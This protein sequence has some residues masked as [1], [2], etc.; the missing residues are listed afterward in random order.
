MEHRVVNEDRDRDVVFILGWGTRLDNANVRRMFRTLGDAGYRV[1]AFQIPTD[2]EDFARDYV[3]PIKEAIGGLERFVLMSHSTGGLIAPYLRTGMPCIFIS[4]WWGIYGFKLRSG[5]IA[6]AK[7][8]RLR[9]RIIPIDFGKEELGDMVTEEDWAG[10]PK[11][12]SLRFVA[13]I[14]KAQENMPPPGERDIVFCSLQDTVVGLDA[15][16]RLMP[17]DRVRLYNGGHEPFSSSDRENTVRA[18]IGELDRLYG[19]L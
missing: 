7:R 5:Q 13:E 6:L 18:I 17:A 10:L 12:V 1:H 16:G 14:A 3:D 19:T 2:I 4:P 15:I 9:A 8:L 11:K